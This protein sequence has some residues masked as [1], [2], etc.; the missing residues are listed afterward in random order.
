MLDSLFSWCGAN[1]MVVNLDKSKFVHF[2]RGPQTAQTNYNITFVNATVDIVQIYK[3]LGMVINKILGFNVTAKIVAKSAS[4]APDLVIGKNV[5]GLVFYFMNVIPNCLMP[6]YSMLLI[7]VASSGAPSPSA[8]Q[9]L[10][11][12]GKNAFIFKVLVNTLQTLLYRATWPGLVRRKNN[13]LMCTDT[14]NVCV[15]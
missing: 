8:A 10:Y 9:M 6:L 12:I 11:S 1:D 15:K 2:R 7:M 13:G 5:K 14:G 4:Q 3:Y